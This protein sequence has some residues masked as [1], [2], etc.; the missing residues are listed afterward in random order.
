MKARLTH[1]GGIAILEISGYLDFDSAFPIKQS[2]ERLYNANQ[3][4]K[5]VIDLRSLEFVGSTGVSS[6]VKSLTSF[7]KMKIKPHYF[8]VK[9]EFVKLFKAFE[10][11]LPFEVVDNKESALKASLDRFNQWQIQNPRS[12]QTH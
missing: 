9:S 4:I 11:E 5:L 3:N 1:E 8:G 2:L 10:E 6:F 12:T 7:N